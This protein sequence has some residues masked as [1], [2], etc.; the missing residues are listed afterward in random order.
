[1][2]FLQNENVVR[3]GITSVAVIFFVIPFFLTFRYFVTFDY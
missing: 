1:M 2:D 3:Y